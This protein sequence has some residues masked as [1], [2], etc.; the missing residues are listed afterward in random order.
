[1][2]LCYHKIMIKSTSDN[3]TP[4]WKRSAVKGTLIG[5]RL[6]PAHLKALDKWIDQQKETYTRP[7]AIRGMIETMLHILSKDQGEKPPKK[8][9]AK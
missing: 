8:A 4:R 6:Q 3:T 1:L 5:V 2:P 9:K 7:E